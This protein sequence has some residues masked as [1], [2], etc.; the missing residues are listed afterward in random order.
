VT[1]IELLQSMRETLASPSAWTKGHLARDENGEPI[2]PLSPAAVCWC[3]TGALA[4]ALDTQ[5]YPYDGYHAD[6]ARDVY[7]A[8]LDEHYDL[9]DDVRGSQGLEDKVVGINDGEW[10]HDHLLTL[11]D[12]AIYHQQHPAAVAA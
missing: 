8:I 3:A 10:G 6:E 1:T 4:K 9:T 12:R 2:A 7:K 11:I 5:G